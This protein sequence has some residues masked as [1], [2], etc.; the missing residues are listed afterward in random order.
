M[1]LKNISIFIV[2][3]IFTGCSMKEPYITEYKMQIEDFSRSET[4]NLC[5]Q[6]SLK[7]IQSFSNH[8]LASTKMHYIV[9]EHKQFIFTKAQWSLPVNEMV[10]IHITNMMDQ[11]NNFRSVQNYKSI[12]KDDYILQSSIIDF[13]QYFSNDLAS[14]YVKVTIKISL[15]DNSSNKV[16]KSKTFTSTVDS[17]TLDSYGGVK[18][19]NEAF[20][21]VLNESSAWMSD[22][23]SE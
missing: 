2:I 11:L 22:V 8:T 6:K 5:S 23:C 10:T 1:M 16:L 12:T 3:V 18:A 13:Q 15:I 19:L 17:K 7:V 4:S 20:I 9:G 21:N 14:S